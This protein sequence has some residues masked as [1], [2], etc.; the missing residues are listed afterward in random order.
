[1][2]ST[3]AARS[4]CR[5]AS[6]TRRRASNWRT[7]VRR[8]K[9]ARAVIVRVAATVTVDPVV[10]A[11]A[12]AIVARVAKAAAVAI[13]VRAVTAVIVVRVVRVA[14]I[15]VLVVRAAIVVRAVKAAMRTARRLSLRRRSCSGMTTEPETVR[16]ELVEAPSF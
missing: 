3:S 1:M 13:V 8:G 9:R 7:A 5:C 6:S 2:R 10:M 14:V 16:A 11:V 12:V 4:A 15:V